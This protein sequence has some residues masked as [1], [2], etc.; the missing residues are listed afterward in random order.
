MKLVAVSSLEA[1]LSGLDSAGAPPL[2]IAASVTLDGFPPIR[3]CWRL[4]SLRFQLARAAR[5][6]SRRGGRDIRRFAVYP[7]AEA[8][9]LLYELDTPAAVY[10][11]GNLLP[12]SGSRI[13]RLAA[14]TLRYFCG[15]D[16]GT[17]GGVVIGK[18]T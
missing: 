11:G 8:P 5:G 15:C 14:T 10:A 9:A 2:Y 16:P 17:G 4:V 1:V 12:A 3:R 6:I 13:K 7:N 18:V